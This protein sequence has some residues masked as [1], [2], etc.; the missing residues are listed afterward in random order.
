MIY[1]RFTAEEIYCMSILN[2]EHSLY[3]IPGSSLTPADRQTVIN[4]LFEKEIA[5]MDMDG[6][7]SLAAGYEELI[8][9]CCNCEKCLTATWSTPEGCHALIFWK[10]G[11][12]CLMAEVQESDYIFSSADPLLVAALIQIPAFRDDNWSDSKAVQFP[13]PVLTKV[14]RRVLRGQTE[15]AL[16]LLQQNGIPMPVAAALADGLQEKAVYAG[17]LYMDNTTGETQ[18]DTLNYL[19]GNGKLLSLSE[20]EVAFRQCAC[21]EEVHTDTAMASIQSLIGRFTKG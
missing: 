9:L 10:T 12:C 20:T 16:R 1:Q 18:T 19:S 17:L 3:G 5:V 7:T 6:R 8:Q 11:D 13:K 21:V 4:R 14:K 2:K 15:D